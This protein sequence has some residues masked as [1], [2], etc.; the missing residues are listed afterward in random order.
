MKSLVA[1]A[2]LLVVAAWVGPQAPPNQVGSA[3]TKP[4]FDEASIRQCDG[5][6]SGQHFHRRGVACAKLGGKPVPW[7]QAAVAGNKQRGLQTP[8]GDNSSADDA[9]P[10]IDHFGAFTGRQQCDQRC[11]ITNTREFGNP[12]LTGSDRRPITT[13]R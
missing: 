3:T 9:A 2:A 11:R 1:T 8:A 12:S 13:V 5:G 7:R 10:R 6:T 4:E